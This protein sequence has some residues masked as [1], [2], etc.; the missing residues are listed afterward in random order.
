[1]TPIVAA[2]RALKIVWTGAHNERLLADQMRPNCSDAFEP[3]WRSWLNDN[4]DA[5]RRLQPQHIRVLQKL[6]VRYFAREITRHDQVGQSDRF[7]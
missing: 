7:Q 4:E 1:M 6:G 3:R 2:H 5:R